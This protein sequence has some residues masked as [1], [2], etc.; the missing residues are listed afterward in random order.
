M[1]RVWLASVC[2][3]L[4]GLGASV[5]DAGGVADRMWLGGGIGLGFGDVDFVSVEP[6][7][8]FDAT[9]RL[10]VGVGL[11]YRYSDDQRYDPDLRTSDY[12]A[13]LF[14]RYTIA[15]RVF[16]QAEY[17]YLDY[18]FRRGDGSSGRDRFGSLLA[19]PGYSRSLGGRTS[20]Y[21]LALYNR[22]YDDDDSPYADPWI[23][24]VGFAVGF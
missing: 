11:I 12:G 21:A 6:V 1:K 16:V 14:A 13:N 5:A 18:E 2:A 10:S 9:R 19:G 23:Y 22:D 17:E 8:G 4:I 7:V 20:F 24:R 3:A 15:S